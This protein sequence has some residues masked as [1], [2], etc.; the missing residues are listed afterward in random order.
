MISTILSLRIKEEIKE[1]KILPSGH[2]HILVTDTENNEMG[3]IYRWQVVRSA[4]QRIKQGRGRVSVGRGRF[5]FYIG[6]QG[7]TH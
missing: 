2:A 1:T 4:V 6:Y 3:M 5:H 7:R